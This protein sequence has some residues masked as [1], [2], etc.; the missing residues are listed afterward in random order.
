ML[1]NFVFVLKNGKKQLIQNEIEKDEHKSERKRKRWAGSGTKTKI[2]SK[3]DEVKP[4]S[5]LV[6]LV[7][8]WL[9]RIVWFLFYVAAIN[10]LY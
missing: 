8:W 4:L 5:R 9:S 6:A 3:N 10:L 1:I 2:L 7:A